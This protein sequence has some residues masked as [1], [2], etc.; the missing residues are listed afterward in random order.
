MSP[1]CSKAACASPA[2]QLRITAQLIR[3]ADS[4]HLWSQ[5]YDRELTDVFKV[6]DEISREVVAAL[7]LK[8]LPG[9]QRIKHPAHAA[10]QRPTSST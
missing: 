8:L 2:T 1:M 5:T 9:K 10:V 4:S 6:Q 3:A 7:K